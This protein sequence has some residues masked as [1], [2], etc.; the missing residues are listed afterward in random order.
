VVLAT[1]SSLSLARSVAACVQDILDIV[2]D[3]DSC[4][5]ISC[6]TVEVVTV[7]GEGRADMV[8]FS[9]SFFISML[10]LLLLFIH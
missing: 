7:S 10:L 6:I 9:S 4:I 1:C 3:I 8:V 5:L 2:F